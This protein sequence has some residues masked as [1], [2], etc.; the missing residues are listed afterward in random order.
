MRIG[1]TGASGFIGSNLAGFLQRKGY[2]VVALVRSEEKAAELGGERIVT[3]VC[4]IRDKT[5]LL[6]AFQDLH[7]V[8]HLAALFNRPEY[9][10][11][12]FRRVNLEGT[13][14]V[15]GAAMEAG[16]RR[17]IHCSTVGVATRAGN[18]PYSEETP[19]SPPAWDKYETTKCE[20]EKAALAFHKEHGL[21]VVVIRPAQVYGPGDRSKAKF[22]RM[23]KKGVIV[24]PG[25]TKKHLI[26]IDDLCSGFEGA[27]SS[28]KAAGEIFIIAGDQVIFLKEYIRL[29]ANE[30]G[31]PVP[32]VI[33]PA[34]AMTCL[35]AVTEFVFNSI[36]RKPPLFRRSMDFFTKSVEFETSKARR[37]LS[38]QPKVPVEEGIS[39]TAEWYLRNNLL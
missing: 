9:T 1:I 25:K 6:G 2:D 3:K 34:T 13:K 27:I 14:D 21:E 31:V 18:P 10:W 17:V 11:E 35:C 12:E 8:I 26:Y 29:V 39:K 38:F 19:Y 5:C 28:Q 33:L 23:V 36:S 4:D 32:K 15:L 22:Y 24:N 30:L 7:A 16:V 20:G 37:V